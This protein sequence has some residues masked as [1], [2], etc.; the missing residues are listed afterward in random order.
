MH[1]VLFVI[2]FFL[3]AFLFWTIGTLQMN[4]QVVYDMIKE[5]IDV[6]TNEHS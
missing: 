4:L 1:T 6:R 3:I 5:V 2:L